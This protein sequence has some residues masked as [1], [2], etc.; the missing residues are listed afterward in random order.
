[1]TRPRNFSTAIWAMAS[2][3]KSGLSPEP[4][5]ATMAP[6]R[7]PWALQSATTTTL[8][9]LRSTLRI[10]KMKILTYT[11]TMAIGTSL[12]CLIHRAS[13]CASLPWVKWGTAFVDLD[14]DG[15]LDLL[16]VNGHVYPQVDLIPSDPGYLQP[17]VLNM[18]QGDGTFCDAS[19]EAGPASKKNKSRVVSPSAI[20]STTAIWTL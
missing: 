4:P 11:A 7:H 6:S 3:K 16:T 5:S 19:D 13:P 18:N 8:V 9:A 17:K 2:L 14:N 1:M 12:K 20:S 10:L 15:W